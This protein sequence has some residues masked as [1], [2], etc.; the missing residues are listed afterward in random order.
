MSDCT[1]VRLL[2]EFAV[3]RY[4]LLGALVAFTVQ[5][6]RQDWPTES[7][8]DWGCKEAVEKGIVPATVLMVS[9]S[10]GG[11]ALEGTLP[12]HFEA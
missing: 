12:L 6:S 5:F 4:A 2:D 3:M 11:A 9:K 10:S 1:K 7:T 8:Q